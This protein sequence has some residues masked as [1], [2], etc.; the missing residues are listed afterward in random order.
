MTL[1]P[2]TQTKPQPHYL[3]EQKAQA[4]VMLQE[5][6]T[7][8]QVA[9]AV[10]CS[11]MT[12]WRWEQRFRAVDQSVDGPLLMDDWTRIARRSQQKMHDMLDYL[13]EHPEDI[14]KHALIP[15][16]YAGTGTDKLLKTKEQSQPRDLAQLVIVINAQQSP[17]EPDYIEGE[18]KDA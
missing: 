9:E 13:D 8:A 17:E 4:L 16:I 15:N 6:H 3:D 5:G 18:V 2:D 7:L 14:A 1:L 12:V 10:G 11:R